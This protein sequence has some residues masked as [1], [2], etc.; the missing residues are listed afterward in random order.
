MMKDWTGA[1]QPGTLTGI[2]PGASKN[3]DT[4]FHA[5]P[6]KTKVLWDRK[7]LTQ[8]SNQFSDWLHHTL[9]SCCSGHSPAQHSRRWAP[10][11]DDHPAPRTVVGVTHR[12]SLFLLTLLSFWIKFQA[13][14]SGK[15]LSDS[16][17][18]HSSHSSNRSG[19]LVAKPKAIMFLGERGAAK[20]CHAIHGRTLLATDHSVRGPQK[21][22]WP[23]VLQ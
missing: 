22:K 20:S 6:I 1:S 11:H 16:C 15:P 17:L 2:R 13:L 19:H 8:N 5:R 7:P 9:E 18:S 14:R 4:E 23:H 10:C 12:C 21:Y 3:W